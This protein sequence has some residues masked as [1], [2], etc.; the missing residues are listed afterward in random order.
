M[1]WPTKTDF[2]DGDV[3]TAAQVNNIGTNLNLANPTGITDGYVLTADGAGSMAWEAPGG[4]SFEVISSGAM[5]G[6]SLNLTSIPQTYTDLYL[7]LS[8]VYN[9]SSVLNMTYNSVTNDY[10]YT[11]INRSGT[12]TVQTAGSYNQPNIDIRPP[13]ITNPSTSGTSTYVAARIFN[14]TEVGRHVAAIYSSAFD[15]FTPAPVMKTMWAWDENQQNPTYAAITS[16]QINSGA[17]TTGSYV[18]YG[19]K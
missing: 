18:L 15:L 5:S 19:A 7:L 8:G 9:I 10:H 2:V 11:N 16:I 3:L 12:S 1:T 4:G 17:S 13:F 14:Y 6:S